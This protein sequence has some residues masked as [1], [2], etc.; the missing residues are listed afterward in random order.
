MEYIQMTLDMWLETKRKL[1]AEL[2]GVRRSFVRIGYLLR[3]IDESKGYENDGYKSIADFAKGEY[4]MEGSTVSRFM[5]INREYSIDGYS[6]ELKPEYEDFKRSQLEEMLK[7]SEPDRK[8][9]TADTARADIRELKA[10]NKETPAAGEADDID[11]LIEQFFRD[12]KDELITIY[13]SNSILDDT[14]QITEIVNPSGTRSYRKG[15][16]FLMMHENALKIKKFGGDPVDMTWDEFAT[17]MINIFGEDFDPNI[18]R[19]HF[20]EEETSE[21]DNADV[22]ADQREESKKTEDTP[23]AHEEEIHHDVEE[24]VD[25]HS[26]TAGN[27]VC[28]EAGHKSNDSADETA[29][30]G[31]ISTGESA[32]VSERADSESGE[33]P[34][35]EHGTSENGTEGTEEVIAP[36]QNHKEILEV[37]DFESR[38]KDALKAVRQFE[39]EISNDHYSDALRMMAGIR[40]KLK[41]L[42]DILHSTKGWS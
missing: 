13:S 4:G 5:S 25:G 32:S 20:G 1:N 24:A 39:R 3:Q 15:M 12:N 41:E 16:Y 37:T 31:Y 40:E 2:L 29:E 38:K 10:F 6:Q 19:T 28:G 33:R 26:E 11:E 18:Y 30:T 36:A 42:K 17:R 34:E 23:L 9:I 22:A 8:M 27:T 7:L 21:Q 14:R 35:E